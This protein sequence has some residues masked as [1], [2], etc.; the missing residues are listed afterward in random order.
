MADAV[1]V[2]CKQRPIVRVDPPPERG[3]GPEGGCY[4]GEVGVGVA[5]DGFGGDVVAEGDV[6]VE[7]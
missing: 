4:G 6:G 3:V 7:A 5:S 1:I 2:Y